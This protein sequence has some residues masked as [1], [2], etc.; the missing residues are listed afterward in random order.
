[1]AM[2]PAEADEAFSIMDYNKDEYI[3]FQ[4]FHSC[5][6]TK[7]QLEMLLSTQPILRALANVMVAVAGG[8]KDP[9]SAYVNL[10]DEDIGAAVARFEPALKK[11]I[12]RSACVC[13]CV[14]V[15]ISAQCCGG[16]KGTRHLGYPWRGFLEIPVGSMDLNLST[17]LD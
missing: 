17:I 16:T 3:T 15:R 4:E 13:A 14:V 7:T 12:R 2:T 11:I 5:T 9:L 8:S 6:K 10:S 1:M